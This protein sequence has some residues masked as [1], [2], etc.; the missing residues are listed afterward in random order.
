[1]TGSLPPS[2]FEAL[3]AADSDPWRFAT[4][5]YEQA[6]YRQTMASLPRER[7]G[8][9]LEVGCSIGILTGLLAA[10]CDKLLALDVAEAALSQARVNCAAFPRVSFARARIPAE[11]PDGT[12][13]LILFSEVLYYLDVEDI[14]RTAAHVC[15]SLAPDGTV[16]L[17]HWTEPTD[18]P[19][20]GDAAVETFI[21]A[22]AGRL[23]HSAHVTQPC[24]RLDRLDCQVG[25]DTSG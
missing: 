6:K 12:F 24:Y 18:Y 15:D 13:D 25:S 14:R 7:Y 20:S 19:M 1:M 17:V 23:A 11:W 10:R 21:A 3:Y 22:C 8:S 5:D 4:S 9:A 2:Y 16:L